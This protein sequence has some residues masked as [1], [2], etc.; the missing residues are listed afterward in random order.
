MRRVVQRDLLEHLLESLVHV[1]HGQFAH[2]QHLRILISQQLA[3]QEPL[4]ELAVREAEHAARLDHLHRDD[5]DAEAASGHDLHETPRPGQD[6]PREDQEDVVAL[7]DLALQEMQ[8][9]E[10]LGVQERR[11]VE[12]LAQVAR[13][14]VLAHG[15]LDL[16]PD[17]GRLGAG[18]DLVVAEEDEV[19]VPLVPLEGDLEVGEELL[20]EATDAGDGQS[21]PLPL[22][23]GPGLSHQAFFTIVGVAVVGV[24]SLDQTLL[25]ALHVLQLINEFLQGEDPH[26]PYR[27]GEVLHV[28]RVE[29][30]LEPPADFLLLHA[31]VRLDHGPV[32]VA[33]VLADLA[34]FVERRAG[35]GVV[36]AEV[37]APFAGLVEE[38]ALAELR[39]LV[40]QASAGDELLEPGGREHHE[41]ARGLRGDQ[42]AALVVDVDQGHLADPLAL[43]EGQ[44]VVL[45]AV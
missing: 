25:E 35:A 6:V 10:V 33:A 8:V 1:A 12:E 34:G 45:R 3:R 32:R 4:V 31:Q 36:V 41:A 23:E 7:V 13:V 42:V 14:V 22:S 29:E 2:R 20:A 21:L 28:V 44:V 43:V 38:D 5:V 9:L 19:L 40:R 39:E 18:L 26:V 11:R 27:G 15:D 17:Q 37:S 24:P 30:L 16:L